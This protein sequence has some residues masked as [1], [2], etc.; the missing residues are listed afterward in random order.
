MDVA[1]FREISCIQRLENETLKALK[2]SSSTESQTKKIWSGFWTRAAK[3]ESK[4]KRK[5]LSIVQSKERK[6]KKT[7]GQVLEPMEK[8]DDIPI[9]CLLDN[10]YSY[11]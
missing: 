3:M 8:N 6:I 10:Q 4:K 9:A 2:V 1:S 7:K 11:L 5:S